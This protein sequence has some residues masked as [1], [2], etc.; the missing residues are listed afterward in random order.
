M[1]YIYTTRTHTGYE[2]FIALYAGSADENNEKK[3]VYCYC[4]WTNNFSFPLLMTMMM[5][6]AA[7]EINWKL[8]A[9]VK[10]LICNHIFLYVFLFLFYLRSSHSLFT[11]NWIRDCR[12]SSSLTSILPNAHVFPL[13]VAPKSIY[14]KAIVLFF[15]LN[16]LWISRKKEENK[17]RIWFH[18]TISISFDF[19]V[20]VLRRCYVCLLGHINTWLSG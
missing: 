11:S 17:I 4:Y 12:H 5:V 16:I 6:P 7:R 14:L 18:C 20:H 2:L 8:Y 10:L 9:T 1:P 19:L 3:G 13:D 15:V